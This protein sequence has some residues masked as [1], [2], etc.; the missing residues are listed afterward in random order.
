MADGY[1]EYCIMNT[2]FPA[3]DG[4]PASSDVFPFCGILSEREE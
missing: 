3:V 2:K 4:L 1:Y